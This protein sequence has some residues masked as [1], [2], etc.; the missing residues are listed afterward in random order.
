[1]DA[2]A[3]GVDHVQLGHGLRQE[4]VAVAPGYLVAFQVILGLA[5]EK[6]PFALK[7]QLIR[8]LDH[9]HPTVAAVILM[10]NAVV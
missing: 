2:V 8:L 9:H 7:N 1:M 4:R 10:R 3:H 5:F 6:K